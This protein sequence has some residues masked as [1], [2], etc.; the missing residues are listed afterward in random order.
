MLLAGIQTLA[1]VMVGFFVDY[2][3]RKYTTKTAL[4]ITKG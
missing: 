4:E 3:I 1:V 2:L